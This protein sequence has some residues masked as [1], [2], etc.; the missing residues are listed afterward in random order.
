ME[1]STRSAST[2]LS[3]TNHYDGAQ[4]NRLDNRPCH[5]VYHL[6]SSVDPCCFRIPSFGIQPVVHYV[7]FGSD[8]GGHSS[9]C[10]KTP[11]GT[12]AVKTCLTKTRPGPSSTIHQ[13]NKT[14]ICRVSRTRRKSRRRLKHARNSTCYEYSSTSIP[15]GVC[16][17]GVESGMEFL[18]LGCF[19]TTEG[20]WN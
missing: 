17:K 4:N 9:C 13:V 2:L 6:S 20:E 1:E 3:R 5:A 12:L 10:I 7:Q 16:T 14:C 8:W 18:G 15:M 11:L 19:R